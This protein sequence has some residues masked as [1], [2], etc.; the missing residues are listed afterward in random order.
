MS[1]S[2]RYRLVLG[3]SSHITKLRNVE[4][5]E[6]LE[7]LHGTTI[8]GDENIRAQVM[9]LIPWACVASRARQQMERG[10]RTYWPLHNTVTG[11]LQR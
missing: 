3:V 5:Y 1:N 11:D 8:S 4:L 2:D 9:R 7:R 6:N 10:R